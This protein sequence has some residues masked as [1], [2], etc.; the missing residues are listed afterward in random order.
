VDPTASGVN[1]ALQRLRFDASGLASRASMPSDVELYVVA[2]SVVALGVV[3]ATDEPKVAVTVLV[4]LAVAGAKVLAGRPHGRDLQATSG[5]SSSGPKPC[6]ASHRSAKASPS[7]P[8]H[9][10]GRGRPRCHIRRRRRQGAPRV[11]ASR[12]RT[13]R[14]PGTPRTRH[15]RPVLI[16]RVRCAPVRRRDGRSSGARDRGPRR[17][18]FP[19]RPRS[20]A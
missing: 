1:P 11:R 7:S 12:G 17:G 20:T 19:R 3:V 18:R 8:E 9:Q 14:R 2:A 5:I 10:S 4:A 13:V 6:S 15:T 16:P